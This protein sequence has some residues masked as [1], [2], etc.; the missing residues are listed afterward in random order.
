MSFF[1]FFIL[2]R[3]RFFA[4]GMEMSSP[5]D[6]RPLALRGEQR[7]SELRFNQLFAVSTPGIGDGR[8][9]SLGFEKWDGGAFSPATS[10]G[11]PLR[12]P[13]WFVSPSRSP[14][15]D[16]RSSFA[17]QWAHWVQMLDDAPADFFRNARSA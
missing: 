13:S 8:G 17:L 2:V 12:G 14:I 10:R 11:R 9:R 15:A 1:V 16:L 7:K 5:V 3:D 6:V 4:L